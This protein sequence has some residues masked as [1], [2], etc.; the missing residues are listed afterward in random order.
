MIFT[1]RVFSRRPARGLALV[2]FLAASL[3]RVGVTHATP[4]V[5]RDINTYVLFA[6]NELIWKGGSV[7][8]NSGYIMGGNIGVNYPGAGITLAFGTS[9]RGIMSAG[10]QAVADSVRADDAQDVFYTLFANQTNP[11]FG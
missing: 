6:Y 7:A 4:I 3:L 9:G 1:T 5:S 11:S 2:V 8:T 10:S